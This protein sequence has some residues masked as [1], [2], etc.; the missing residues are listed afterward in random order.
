LRIL[1]IDRELIVDPH[2]QY[3]WE[4]IDVQCFHNINCIALD[5]NNWCNNEYI[6]KISSKNIFI[7]VIHLV[8]N[9]ARLGKIKEGGLSLFFFLKKASPKLVKRYNY[10]IIIVGGR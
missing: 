2:N 9:N 4:Q 6:N 7:I 1:K 8:I 3:D 5:N 10:N